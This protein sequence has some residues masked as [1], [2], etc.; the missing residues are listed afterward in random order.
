M[1]TRKTSWHYKLFL[2]SYTF[3]AWN[4]Y[5]GSPPRS[6]PQ[7]V[8]WLRIGSVPFNAIGCGLLICVASPFAFLAWLWNACVP[9]VLQ[10][11]FCA[12]LALAGISSIVFAFSMV[13]PPILPIAMIAGVTI[14]V[15]AV[16]EQP[17]K[18]LW[19]GLE[20]RSGT[21]RFENGNDQ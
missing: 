9:S 14:F 12:L 13:F 10:A 15:L 4:R 2:R 18:K 17:L 3:G 1:R 6:V 5:Y 11:I 19:R 7:L 20:A 21:I 8:Y 16:F